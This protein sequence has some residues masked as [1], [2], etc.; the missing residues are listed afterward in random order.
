MRVFI[1]NDAQPGTGINLSDDT[2]RRSYAGRRPVRNS[3]GTPL[4]DPDVFAD[5][6]ENDPPPPRPR[7]INDP[8]V[9]PPLFGD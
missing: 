5:D 8:L 3:G 7:G 6:P 4:P 1:I 2:K 9:A